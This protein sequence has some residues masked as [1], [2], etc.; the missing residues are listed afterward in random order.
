MKVLRIILVLLGLL[1][2]LTVGIGFFGPSEI[3]VSHKKVMKA[4]LPAVWEQ[5]VEFKNW[6]NW[7]PW[8]ASD[9]DM[10]IT[11]NESGS[12]GLSGGYS[13]KGPKSGKGEMEIREIKEGE[14][15]G[16]NIGVDMGDGMEYSTCDMQFKEV[17]GGTEVTWNWES[18]GNI[19]FGERLSNVIM[20][21]IL[22]GMYE[23]GLNGLEKAA[24]SNPFITEELEVKGI[25][26]KE[27][28]MPELF[29]IGKRYVDRN[30][31]EITAKMYASS[32]KDIYREVSGNG[33]V[34]KLVQPPIS[35]TEAFDNE[36]KVSTFTIAIMSTEKLYGGLS[37]ATDYIKPHKA[38]VYVH[39]GSYETLPESYER[40]MPAIYAKELTPLMPSYEVYSIGP[41]NEPDN[42][43]WITQIVIPLEWIEAM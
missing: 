40:L 11:Y 10:K 43:K 22:K 19:S 25:A 8:V 13:W 17:E 12:R 18:S 16:I 1:A 41:I 29:Y 9:Q 24:I 26:M 20:P 7:S 39:K 14:K 3:S 32:Y 30:K 34:S 33:E 15:I 37:L 31:E 2:L 6:P 23:E 35:V 36:T 28:E 21:S 27:V 42:S 5:V 4:P 38:M